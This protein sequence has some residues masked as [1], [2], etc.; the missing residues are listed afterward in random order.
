MHEIGEMSEYEQAGLLK[1]IPEL[2]GSI[3]KG[4]KFAKGS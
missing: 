2:A 3:D 4:V 1:L